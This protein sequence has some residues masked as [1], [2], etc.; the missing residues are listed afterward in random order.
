[1]LLSELALLYKA[2]LDGEAPP[3][4]EFELLQYGD[5]AA[6]QRTAFRREGAAYQEAIAWWKERF[7]HPPRL[8]DLP[9]KRS[10]PLVGFDPAEGMMSSPVIHGLVQ[11]LNWLRRNEATTTYMVWLAALVALLA[12]ETGQSDIV[13]GTY[14]TTRR[15]AELQKMMGDFTNLAE[16]RFHCD[17]VMSFRDWLSEVR[18][19]VTAAEARSEILHVS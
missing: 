10:A 16:L 3:L 5:Y 14:V 17:H 13:I 9:F 2:K 7:E 4:P 1:M 8:L 12:A 11:H 6:W 15:G 18:F 19:W